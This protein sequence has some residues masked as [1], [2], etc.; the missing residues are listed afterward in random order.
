VRRSYSL[1]C[2]A[3]LLAAGFAP[4]EAGAQRFTSGSVPR[5][6]EIT[7]LDKSYAIHGNTARALR[8]QMRILGPRGGWMSFPF[9]FEWSYQTQVVL[10]ATG[11][12]TD[13][14]RVVEFEMRFTV[15]G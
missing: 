12:A 4:S 13:M 11:F 2:A 15:E 1:S 10:T 5:G 8:E 14:C 7:L 3:L 9:S 6:I